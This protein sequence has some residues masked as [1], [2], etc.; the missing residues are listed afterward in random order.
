MKKINQKICV[1]AGDRPV[2]EFRPLQDFFIGAVRRYAN[3]AWL[4][5]DGEYD[6]AFIGH[7]RSDN[8]R[9][10][11]CLYVAYSHQKNIV[12]GWTTGHWS[13]YEPLHPGGNAWHYSLKDGET[14]WGGDWG[15]RNH[16]NKKAGDSGMSKMSSE[17]G[18]AN[19][20]SVDLRKPNDKHILAGLVRDHTT[21]ELFQFPGRLV[22][23]YCG[24]E[25][26]RERAVK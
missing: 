2:Y 26:P 6:I 13:A 19:G 11:C 5:D 25:Y 21:K 9:Y 18:C 7:A 14:E 16:L 15:G 22:C 17:N 23:M 1:E 20:R 10:P 12:A 3:G 4:P 24:A 8:Y